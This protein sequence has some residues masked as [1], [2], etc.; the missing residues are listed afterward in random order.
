MTGSI[1]EFVCRG[2]RRPRISLFRMWPNCQLRRTG[3]THLIPTLS[4]QDSSI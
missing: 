2:W 1:L 3:T 4:V